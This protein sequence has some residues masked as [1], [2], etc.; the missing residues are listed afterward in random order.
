MPE[1][2]KNRNINSILNGTWN[3]DAQGS[4]ASGHE[5]S[6]PAVPDQQFPAGNEIQTPEVANDTPQPDAA[7][8]QADV[9]ST[10]SGEDA[11]QA[12]EQPP[13][14][15]LQQRKPLT[16]QQVKSLQAKSKTKNKKQKKTA[17]PGRLD[18]ISDKL[19]K[20]ALG[21]E[22][23]NV[24]PKQKMNLVAMPVL[25]VVFVFMALKMFNVSGP[26]K[27]VAQ[28]GKPVTASKTVE[29]ITNWK[30]PEPYPAE[31]PDPMTGKTSLT[32]GGS[33]IV[34]GIIYSQDKPLAIIDGQIVQEGQEILGVRIL[35]IT[36]DTVE[37]ASKGKTW[38]QKL[39]DE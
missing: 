13:E 30:L 39:N 1:N 26:K 35:K 32:A 17:Q 36:P 34:T 28:V 33:A 23:K 12:A 15:D 6:P 7:Q 31:L 29:K 24:S 22:W 16:K 5:Q 2:N 14:Q 25:M 9:Q 4:C 19:C 21:S 3:P 37:F 8:L 11:P 10:V 38:K 20:K 27:A 18:G